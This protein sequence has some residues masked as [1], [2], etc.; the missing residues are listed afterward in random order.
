MGF[1]SALRN[2]NLNGFIINQNDQLFG[3]Y[4]I[5]LILISLGFLILTKSDSLQEYLEEKEKKHRSPSL[6]NVVQTYGERKHFNR[7]YSGKKSILKN[8]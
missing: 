3:I 2:I 6:E 7:R 8:D 5:P 4:I 1:F